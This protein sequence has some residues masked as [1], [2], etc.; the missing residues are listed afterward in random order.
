MFGRKPGSSVQR[1]R[2]SVRKLASEATP[3]SFKSV[4]PA[5][6]NLSAGSTKGWGVGGRERRGG[7]GRGD[8]SDQQTSDDFTLKELKVV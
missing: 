8:R 4:S 6:Q 7:T 5:A 2:S 3:A 1:Q